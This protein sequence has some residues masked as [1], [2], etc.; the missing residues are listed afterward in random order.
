MSPA[1]TYAD[2]AEL[3]RDAGYA[4][5]VSR[6]GVVPGPFR[7]MQIDW[8]AHA[9]I[10]DG[11]A[12]LA[13]IPPPRGSAA[14]TIADSASTWLAA[15]SIRVAD[16]AVLA[17]C[18][19]VL[20]RYG[21][22]PVRVGVDGSRTF[23]FRTADRL[24]PAA[25]RDPAGDAAV[26]VEQNFVSLDGEWPAGDLINTRRDDL[27]ELTR[28]SA[29]E[30]MA[31]AEAVFAKHAPMPPVFVPKTPRPAEP[32]TVALK[33][34]N[35]AAVVG[36][37]RAQGYY[38]VTLPWGD[39]PGTRKSRTTPADACDPS[40]NVYLRAPRE[41]GFQLGA[42]PIECRD[43]WL[44]SVRISVGPKIDPAE[45]WA[46][47]DRY[48]AEGRALVR[49][50]ADGSASYVFQHDCERGQPFAALSIARS[51]RDATGCDIPGTRIHVEI[52]S[53]EGVVPVVA[54]TGAWRDATPLT[55][56]R[57]ELPILDRTRAESL[58]AAVERFASQPHIE[59]GIVE[60]VKRAAGGK[61][62]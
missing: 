32:A 46:I 42:D 41:S 22:A 61:R 47:V 30:L 53:C 13:A 1:L 51:R 62:K 4:P 33:R 52:K 31:A 14:W 25:A 45:V 26:R 55:I 35:W 19:T 10:D 50:N 56:R 21:S 36:A 28:S 8:D 44:V 37:L 29:A 7:V 12:V 11:V 15:V 58:L 23:V 2:C 27:P 20:A 3:L 34:E 48:T 49:D 5:A 6:D 57:D 54:A 38:P 59:P 24:V 9:L 60:R 18:E 39:E 17:E 16:P 40:V 43:T